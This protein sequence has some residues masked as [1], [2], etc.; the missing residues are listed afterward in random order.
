MRLL[1]ATVTAVKR[2]HE[3]FTVV[4]EMFSTCIVPLPSGGCSAWLGCDAEVAA[5]VQVREEDVLLASLAHGSVLRMLPSV[6]PPLLSAAMLTSVRPP[7]AG[8]A[9]SGLAVLSVV[10]LPARLSA[11]A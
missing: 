7:P 5:V 6:R 9:S 10:V 4:K 3:M 2:G 8:R 11:T 1:S